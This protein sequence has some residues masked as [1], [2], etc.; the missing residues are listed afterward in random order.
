MGLK[1]QIVFPEIDYDQVDQIRGM[2][3][4]ICTSANTD[5]EARALLQ[6]LNI[7]FSGRK[8][9]EDKAKT[10]ES[11]D[12][13]AAGQGAQDVP[14]EGDEVKPEPAAGESGIDETTSETDGEQQNG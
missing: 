13:E 7:P 14:A 4:V 6:A 12:V 10:S 1:E 11:A 3:I 5:E 9:A 2:D 8:V